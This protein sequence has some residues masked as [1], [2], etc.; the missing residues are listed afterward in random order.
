ML[1]RK[2][3]TIILFLIILALNRAGLGHCITPMEALDMVQIQYATNFSRVSPEENSGE[4]Y[5][6]LDSAEYYLVYEEQE[7]DSFYMIH[8]YEFILDEPDTGIGHT[9]TYGWYAVNRLTGEIEV[10]N[11]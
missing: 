10:R 5:Y 8:L 7:E 6:K 3:E 4:Y 1:L 11:Y 2:T 9:Y